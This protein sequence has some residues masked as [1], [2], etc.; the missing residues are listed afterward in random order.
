MCLPD[1]AHCKS[2]GYGTVKLHA[3]G[4]DLADRH[5][6]MEPGV[7]RLHHLGLKRAFSGGKGC[8]VGFSGAS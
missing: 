7:D 5:V 8:N 3:H 2:E 1:W 4:H 6:Q